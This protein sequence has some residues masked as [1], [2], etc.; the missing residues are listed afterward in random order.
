MHYEHL[1]KLAIVKAILEIMYSDEKA[2]S[3]EALYLMQLSHTLNFNVDL[4]GEARKL[5]PEKGA[6]ILSAMGRDKKANFLVMLLEMA[7]ADG[8]FTLEELQRIIGILYM[9]DF[10]GEE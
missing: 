3:G 9:S 2:E 5:D 8:D 1:E 10:F 6:A 4:M 7:R